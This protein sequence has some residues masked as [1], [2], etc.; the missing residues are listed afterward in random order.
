MEYRPNIRETGDWLRTSDALRDAC[1][2][3]GRDVAD[4]AAS[5]APVDSGAYLASISVVEAS[6]TDRVGV[7]VEADVPYAAAVEFGNTATRGRGQHVLTR[8]AES[9][10][11]DMAGP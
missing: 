3:A 7:N 4:A 5:I 1:R 8:A 6:G 2:A 9:V 11:L 10:G